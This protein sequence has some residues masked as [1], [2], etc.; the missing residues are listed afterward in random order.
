LDEIMDSITMGEPSVKLGGTV[1][2]TLDSVH[3][4]ADSG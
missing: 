4:L 3:D 1:K 2:S